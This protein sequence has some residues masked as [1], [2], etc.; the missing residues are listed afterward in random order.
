MLRK[1]NQQK[2]GIGCACL[3]DTKE[4]KAWGITPGVQLEMT[5]GTVLK[6]KYISEH[7]EIEVN[8]GYLSR[9]I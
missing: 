2:M 6:A 5:A 7:V 9:D 4:K 3:C 8:L 1:K